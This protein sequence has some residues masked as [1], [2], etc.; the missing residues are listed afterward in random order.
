MSERTPERLSVEWV[1]RD[2][3]LA[4]AAALG[5]GPVAEALVRA[6]LQRSDEALAR[7]SGVGS[8]RVVVVMGEDLPW[9]DGLVYLGSDPEAPALLLPTALRPTVPLPLLQRAVLARLPPGSSPVALSPR[10][11]QLVALGG[12]RPLRRERLERR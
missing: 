7:L 10:T 4:P 2:E 8:A 5:T 9:V 6:L 3:P 12:S 1:P 11:R